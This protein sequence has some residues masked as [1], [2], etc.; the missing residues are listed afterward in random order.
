MALCGNGALA[1]S[2]CRA[3]HQASPCSQSVAKC[4][5]VGEHG[6]QSRT[7]VGR[8]TTQPCTRYA[9]L[10]AGGT[11]ASETGNVVPGNRLRVSVPCPYARS[12]S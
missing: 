5:D 2:D 10:D 6:E 11:R 9:T 1:H 12:I 3:P 7:L 8:A 4:P